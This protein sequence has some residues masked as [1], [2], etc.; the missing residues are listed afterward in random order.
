MTLRSSPRVTVAIPT[1]NRADWLRKAM[2]SVHAQTYTDFRLVVAD[3]AS[4]DNTAEVV[5][6]LADSRVEYVR[7]PTNVGSQAN[8]NLLLS[9]ITTEFVLL[10]PDDDLLY[11]EHL[12]Q[13]VAALDKHPSVGFVDAGFDVV[14]RDGR[15]VVPSLRRYPSAHKIHVESRER[16]RRRAMRD[17]WAV[18]WS[19]ALIRTRAAQSA[20]P[21]RPEDLPADDLGLFLRISAAWDVAHL[22][23]VLGTLRIHSDAQTAEY[24][25][26]TGFGYEHPDSFYKIIRDMR[27]RSISSWELSSREARSLRRMAYS[28]F[29][30]ALVENIALESSRESSRFAGLR[31]LRRPIADDPRLLLAPRTWRLVAAEL[32][33]RRL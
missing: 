7:R 23:D 12:E 15:I 31:R 33:G 26:F 14:D 22:R 6:Q 32:G 19:T 29:R 4:T 13:A 3:N 30:C 25:V 8:F 17:H 5:A 9:D 28:S 11:P 20:A 21:F 1:Y 18:H 2:E 10:L 16:F 27:L 24:G